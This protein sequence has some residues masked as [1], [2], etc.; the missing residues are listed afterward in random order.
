MDKSV[1]IEGLVNRRL[2]VEL[3]YFAPKHPLI[4]SK[5]LGGHQLFPFVSLKSFMDSPGEKFFSGAAGPFN[6]HAAAFGNSR[7]DR[8]E[9]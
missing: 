6:H 5:L 9:V 3:F 7:K 1:Q 2:N 4:D 8:K